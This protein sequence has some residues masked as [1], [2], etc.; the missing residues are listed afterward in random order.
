MSVIVDQK[1]LAT[2]K[3]GLQTVGQLLSHLRQGDRF[4]VHLL[5]DGQQ[6]DLN[7]I[8]LVRR[9]SLQGRTVFIE[10]ANAREMALQV[11]DE[12]RANL[13]QADRAKSDAVDL[14]QQDHI[15][16]AMEKLGQC[17][18][19]WQTAQESV[20]KTSQLL[21][22]DIDQL[23]MGGQSIPAFLNEFTSQLRQIKEALT[24][25]DDVLLSDMLRYETQQ[26]TKR[27][28]AV[29]A[30]LRESANA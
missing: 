13:Q 3:L 16:E 30:A 9:S 6:P 22:I 29:I 4:V 15:S 25:R 14:L 21:H 19:I 27:W 20:L 17:L 11:L 24:N 28:Q 23:G 2:D 5:I 26:T 18:T 1:P 10:T 7:Q 8:Q 12:V